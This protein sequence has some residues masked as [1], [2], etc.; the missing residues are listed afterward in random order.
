ML[1][2]LLMCH[3]MPG[4][5]ADLLRAVWRPE[6]LYIVHVDAKAGEALRATVARF[7]EL[8]NVHVLPAQLCSWGGWS[9]VEVLLRGVARAVTLGGDWSHLIVLSEAHLPLRP[10]DA[11][12]LQPGVSRI[13]AAPVAQTHALAQADVMHRLRAR[14]RELPGVG[15]FPVGPAMVPDSLVEVLH[16]GTQWMVLAHNACERLQRLGPESPVWA[17]FRESLIA[18]ETAVQTVLLGTDMGRG[19]VNDPRPATF[20]AWPHVS[21]NGDF[22]HTDAN[23]FAAR[24]EGFLFIRKRPRKLSEPVAEI[25]NAMAVLPEVPLADESFV[26]GAAAARLG[27]ALH[28]ML[29]PMFDGLLVETLAPLRAGGSPS[30]FLRLRCAELPRDLH[31]ALLSEDF[32]TFKALLAWGG[33]PA[34]EF[35]VRSL[36][37]YPTW[38]LKVR[39]WD[40]FE[41]R[42]VMLP[43]TGF[44]SV[45]PG[46]G[47]GRI[48]GLLARVLGA[49]IALA[50]A[51]PR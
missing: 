15:M 33:Q 48:A 20:V 10:P 38:L 47:P 27:D 11:M 16:H 41:L 17:P 24:D 2:Y 12:G 32:A 44:L 45:A 40:L 51:M 37:G 5:V 42:E 29:R 22:T 4:A 49:G 26:Q 31:V 39:L 30:C 9:L 36:G 23:F 28:A 19:L 21:G 25:V 3:R 50:P 43:D 18:D 6:H 1:A 7:A 35:G 13:D 8:P 46:E 14:Y 34:D